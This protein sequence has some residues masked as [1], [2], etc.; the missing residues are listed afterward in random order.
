MKRITDAGLSA[1]SSSCKELKVLSFFNGNWAPRYM[2]KKVTDIGI[3]SV[4]RG[5]P[6][7]KSLTLRYF[8]IHDEGMQ[9]KKIQNEHG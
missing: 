5:C 3:S 6:K 4:A 9:D 2:N 7:L 1:L 8:S